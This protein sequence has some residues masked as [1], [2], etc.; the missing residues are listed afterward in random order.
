MFF[1]EYNFRRTAWHIVGINGQLELLHKLWDCV[2]EVLTKDKLRK[3]L[4]AKDIAEWTA[5]ELAAAR[6]H[7][8][9]LHKLWE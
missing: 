8:E 1:A 2:K 3:M 4:L 7:L 6:S 9:L 5:W